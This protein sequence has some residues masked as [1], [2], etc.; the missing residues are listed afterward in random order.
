M[1]QT[2]G[3]NWGI[4][5]Q[6]YTPAA[7]TDIFNAM[8]R[9]Q[10]VS[11]LPFQP[12]LGQTVAGFA[13]SEIAAM[14]GI[15]GLQGYYE[16]YG[17][18]AT[19]LLG[20]AQAYANP[21][22]PRL[23]QILGAQIPTFSQQAVQQYYSPYQKNVIDATMA[24][25][26]QEN[27]RQQNDL[28]AR[29]I[30][31][32]GFGGDR[33]GIAR[34]E[35][36]RLQNLQNAQTLSQLQN[37]GYAQALGAFQ[38]QQDFARQ[39]QA[40]DFAQ[41][42]AARNA[43]IQAAQQGAYSLGQLGL[44]GQQAGMQGIQAL[45]GVGQMERALGQAQL[46]DQFKRYMTAM[47]YPWETAQW[48][49]SI[50]GSL[51]PQAGGTT[52]GVSFGGSSQQTP[53]PSQISSIAGLAT[54]GLG[55]LLKLFPG[56]GFKDGG[57]VGK[58]DG[59]GFGEIQSLGLESPWSGFDPR[60]LN[61]EK[62][63]QWVS[64]LD[65]DEA[66]KDQLRERSWLNPDETYE[67]YQDEEEDRSFLMSHGGRA[68]Y[69]AGGRPY[70]GGSSYIE[71]DT[72]PY[73]DKLELAPPKAP[74]IP[75]PKKPEAPEVGKLEG[76]DSFGDLGKMIGS[77]GTNVSK[78][79]STRSS[80]PA[81]AITADEANTESETASEEQ[82]G[83]RVVKADGG[84][85]GNWLSSLRQAGSPTAPYLQNQASQPRPMIS[86]IGDLY[87]FAFGREADPEGA[88]F[89]QQQQ[90]AGMSLGDIAKNILS[91]QEAV[92]RYGQ[93]NIG[94]LQ[95]V[96]SKFTSTPAAPGSVSPFQTLLTTGGAPVV[97]PD[98]TPVTL[99]D[100]QTPS[101]VQG[102]PGQ[103]PYSEGD[104]AA[105]GQI[106]PPDAGLMLM[107]GKN[108]M[109]AVVIN[110]Q[111]QEKQAAANRKVAEMRAYNDQV[112]N[113]PRS[114]IGYF[115]NL[116]YRTMSPSGL[117]GFNPIS[118]YYSPIVPTAIKRNAGGKVE[119][120][121]PGL[122]LGGIAR[123]PGQTS[124]M[125]TGPA[126]QT[127]FSTNPPGYNP[128]AY[129]P[130]RESGG[131][132]GMRDGGDPSIIDRIARGIAAIESGG[133]KNPYAVVGAR[134]RKGDRPYGKYQ[135]MGANIPSWGREAGYPNLTVREFLSNPKI[136][137]DVARTQFA[138]IFAKS[139]SPNAVAGEWLGG[140]GWRR[141]RSADVLGTTVPEYIRRFARAYGSPT[142]VVASS[143]PASQT[144]VRIAKV[145]P[146]TGERVGA[147]TSSVAPVSAADAQ[148]ENRTRYDYSKPSAERVPSAGSTVAAPAKKGFS[149]SDLN[150]IGSAQ[151]AEAGVEPKPESF[152]DAA[153]R[154]RG[155]SGTYAP[156]VTEQKSLYTDFGNLIPDRD[157]LEETP[158]AQTMVG[159]PMSMSI[160]DGLGFSE[161]SNDVV[162]EEPARAKP[163][164]APASEK[165]EPEKGLY[166][167]D[168]RDYE[169]WKSDPI[170]GFFDELMGEKPQSKTM[171]K[172][173]DVNSG[174]GLGFLKELFSGR[175]SGGRMGYADGGSPEDEDTLTIDPELLSPEPM[176]PTKGFDLAEE[177]T[178]ES[179]VVSAEEAPAT[180]RAPAASAAQ[181][182]AERGF[183]SMLGLDRGRLD[184]LADAMIAAGFGMMA[185][186]S[187]NA[188]QN[189][190]MGGLKGIEAYQAGEAIRARR[191]GEL[192]KI[193]QKEA[194]S[195]RERNY[196][197]EFLGAPSAEAAPIRPVSRQEGADTELEPL[198]DELERYQR[199]IAAA[200]SPEAA[201]RLKLLQD[202][203]KFKIQRLKEAQ[204]QKERAI[205]KAPSSVFEKKQAEVSASEF[206]KD[207]QE[208]QK[209][210][211]AA[212]KS[213]VILRSTL[214]A[215]NDPTVYTG[216]AGETVLETKKKMA[217]LLDQFPSL[218]NVIP[219]ML[220]PST[221]GIAQTEMLKSGAIKSVLEAAG[222]RFG[223]GFSDGD[224]RAMEAA[225]FGVGTSRE[226]NIKIIKQA[227]AAN[228]RIQEIAR[229]QQD[230]I[231]RNGVLDDG[232]NRELQQYAK[233]NPLFDAKG[234]P[235]EEGKA[236][237]ASAQ[238]ESK[239][240]FTRE[241][242]QEELRR[243]Q[244][245]R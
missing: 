206:A 142:D 180:R 151:A 167:G 89:W 87:K 237:P 116:D 155:L 221:S 188:F 109:L 195:D 185:G 189:I 231:S 245:A 90:Q 76:D 177:P 181:K 179:D 10:D 17:Q 18:Q 214:D 127:S 55:A 224:R 58:A 138:K 131:R 92:S 192:A 96:F 232:F 136:Q 213:D 14:R 202:N 137:E 238:P 203:I 216:A 154:M 121:R 140:P 211:E 117:F 208:T 198:Y 24:N 97:N 48:L 226:G 111:Q 120:P 101:A 102:P 113:A 157:M 128:N 39:K 217:G 15:Y 191:E 65:V 148:W 40:Q 36:N 75:N 78:Y 168:F 186:K 98:G 35:L 70:E 60:R 174:D 194:E 100:V 110:Q 104:I 4:Y 74:T 171:G 135:I 233:A 165:R 122:D 207:Y 147:A 72:V 141:N 176:G 184:S 8:R 175:A 7:Q 57:R 170:G 56:A 9:A 59:G 6:T 218:K 172:R 53:G 45:M 34:A 197:T 183:G 52:S 43:A 126:S 178:P 239:P 173:P 241:Q 23:Q 38:Q 95:D 112:Y 159:S 240:R 51:G 84:G 243:R 64:R 47:G 11:Q 227:Q 50:V 119:E 85:F 228:N 42:S 204:T 236:P 49:A 61:E 103:G 67:P 234:N 244:G 19:T 63:R 82:Y 21:N 108:P 2:T 219:E 62:M 201:R 162:S 13:P 69:K 125:M 222:G 105:A 54:S 145:R 107:V 25:I 129:G 12:Y 230:Y 33:T 209:A 71:S 130:Y 132:V 193:R 196:L 26:A 99:E 44:Q 146:L 163:Q 118:P 91:S 225:S 242:I 123:L 164:A 139:G 66:V 16:P 37:Q 187:P 73:I 229:M 106:S 210:A 81:A 86:N 114:P 161:P 182:P 32:G 149:L 1:P 88:R 235:V 199:G 20:Q 220:T 200:P 5:N 31:Q 79:F 22:D 190:G 223:A 160:W 27:L 134:S 133:S 212:R 152:K 77:L 144:P 68:G 169:P 166:F 153:A 94:G 158:Y 115:M 30:Q 156:G 3:Q 205:E 28:T 83:G 215:L 124:S 150:P 143:R 46:E 41:Y 93:E 80:N 29:A